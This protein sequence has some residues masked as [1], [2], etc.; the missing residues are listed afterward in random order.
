M[1]VVGSL[2]E[3]IEYLKNYFYFFKLSDWLLESHDHMCTLTAE[4]YIY[5]SDIFI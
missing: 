3:N 2:N 5:I 4:Y 1:F